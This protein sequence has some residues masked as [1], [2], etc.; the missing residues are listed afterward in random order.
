MSRLYRTVL[1]DDAWHRLPEAVRA[2][3]GDGAPSVFQGTFCV[4]RGANFA[5]RLLAPLLRVPPAG[6]CVPVRLI[7]ETCDDGG[8][9]WLRWFGDHLLT[10][11]QRRGDDGTL[12]ERF[13]PLELAFALKVDANGIDYLQTAARLRCWPSAWRLPRWMSPRVAAREEVAL[14]ERSDELRTHVCVELSL[15]LIGRIGKYDGLLLDLAPCGA[16]R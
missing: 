9:R 12:R 16:S 4:T 3:H 15:P 2:A 10:T 1:G 14:G 11:S 6:D 5:A 8:E 13:G 7:V